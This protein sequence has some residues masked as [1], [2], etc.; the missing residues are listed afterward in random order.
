M[1]IAT[2]Q[3]ASLDISLEFLLNLQRIFA[4]FVIFVIFAIFVKIATFQGALLHIFEFATNLWRIFAKFAIFVVAH[5]SGHMTS[6]LTRDC[7]LLEQAKIKLFCILTWDGQCNAHFLFI[8]IF[9]LYLL[10]TGKVVRR[11]TSYFDYVG[12]DARKP[13][14]FGEGTKRI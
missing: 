4:K 5:I 13:L 8:V 12:V 9:F 6:R 7:I 11:W 10:Q 3:G 2:F 14:F 1:K